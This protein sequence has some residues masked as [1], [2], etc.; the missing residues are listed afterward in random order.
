MLHALFVSLRGRPCQPS[1][2]DAYEVELP[3]SMLFC[4]AAT[5]M[6]SAFSHSDYAV[7][8]QASSDWKGHVEKR[9]E[10]I[11][12]YIQIVKEKNTIGSEK[13]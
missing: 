4:A 8:L 9:F 10:S 5:A 1:K 13:L 7:F 2:G 6:A 3:D 12:N 11:S